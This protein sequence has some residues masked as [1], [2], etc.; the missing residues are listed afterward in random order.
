MLVYV[1]ST[2]R[3]GEKTLAS[4][5]SYIS[6]HTLHGDEREASRIVIDKHLLQ[7]VDDL[8]DSALFVH[9]RGDPEHTAS[10]YQRYGFDAETVSRWSDLLNQPISTTAQASSLDACR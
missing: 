6:N 10:I 9:L 1:L 2:G 8:D 3:C 5:C 7:R 4:A